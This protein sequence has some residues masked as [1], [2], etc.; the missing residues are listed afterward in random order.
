MSNAGHFNS[1]HVHQDKLGRVIRTEHDFRAARIRHHDGSS[2]EYRAG[3]IVPGSHV[4]AAKKEAR[5]DVPGGESK[6]YKGTEVSTIVE[7]TRGEKE[8]SGETEMLTA[9]VRK[10]ID[11]NARAMKL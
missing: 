9:A 1:K 4:D 3:K 5:K 2:A 10:K 6:F 11:V 7:R 8:T